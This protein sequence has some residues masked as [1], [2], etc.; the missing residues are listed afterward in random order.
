MA[1]ETL[2]TVLGGGF[3]SRLNMN[4]REDKHWAYG[5][6]SGLSAAEGQGPFIVRAPVQTDKTSESVQEIV[7]ELRGIHG[8]KPPSDEED[9]VRAR[10]L[11]RC[12]FRA[13]TRRRAKWR[14]PTPT[15]SRTA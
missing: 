7:K 2:N 6:G 8:P 10:Q 15:S 1:I 9:Q 11:S 5:A 14:A 3:V 4:L 12:S 13:A